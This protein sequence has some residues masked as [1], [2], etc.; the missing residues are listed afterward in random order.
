[1][2]TLQNSSSRILKAFLMATMITAGLLLLMTYLI[3]QKP[4]TT[5]T[6]DWQPTD[7]IQPDTTIEDTYLQRLKPKI[8]K[9][10]RSPHRARMTTEQQSFA[11]V[12]LDKS[13]FSKDDSAI[14]TTSTKGLQESILQSAGDSMASNT[15]AVAARYPAEALKKAIEGYVDVIFDITS[16]G[17]TTNVRILKAEPRRVFDRSAIKA[18]KR[19][20]YRPEVRSGKA[21]ATSGVVARLHFQLENH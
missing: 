1:M 9:P 20:K 5:S 2:L 14:T 4:H 13:L 12:K 16:T 11:S 15:T 3:A 8:T 18:V 10:K 17:A 7:V 19:W 21:V 6:P